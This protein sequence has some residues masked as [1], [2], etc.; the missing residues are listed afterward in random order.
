MRDSVVDG[1]GEAADELC[2]NSDFLRELDARPRNARVQYSVLLGTGARLSEDQV[3]WI[4]ESVCDSLAK[5]P[6]SDGA[7]ERLEAILDDIDE[8]VD[9]KG[10]GVVAVKRG[11]LDGVSDTIVMRFGHLSVTGEPRDDV[12]REVQ[13]LVLARVQVRQVAE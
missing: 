1:L 9:G 11:R 6:G 13:Q 12:Q 5:L 8:L 3:I 7:V 10:D 4:R 2:P